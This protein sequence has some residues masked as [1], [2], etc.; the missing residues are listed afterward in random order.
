MV[1]CLQRHRYAI[2]LAAKPAGLALGA[3]LALS[4]AALAYPLW[5][6]F[7]GPAHYVGPAWPVN[8]GY[9]ADALDFV[10][11]TPNQA[12]APVLREMGT[13]LSAYSGTEDGAYLGLAVL[14]VLVCLVWW[15]RRSTVVRLGAGL[16]VIS[17][18][19]SLGRHLAVDGRGGNVPLPFDLLA[20]LPALDNILPIRFAFTTDACLAAVIAFGLDD[21]VR[22]SHERS[23]VSRQRPRSAPLPVAFAFTVVSVALVVTWLP[24]WPYPSQ[25]VNL[26]PVAVTKAIPAGNPIILAYPYPIAPEDQANLWQA[27][28]RRSFRL[29]GVYGFVAGVGRRSTTIPPLLNPPA[30]QEYLVGED[31]VRRFYPA[32]PQF[33]PVSPSLDQVVSQTRIFVARYGVQAVLVDLA[34]PHGRTVADMFTTAL[35]QPVVTSGQFDLWNLQK[36]PRSHQ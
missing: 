26:L 6:E 25:A 4:G 1:Y 7:D 31:G 15:C 34:A 21:L 33:Y 18:A 35:G 29:F 24:T 30:V 5:H 28:A 2:R 27:G 13:R 11:P 12:V 22:R 23:T 14:V 19:L 16:A 8:N 3:T 17:G 36:R 20:H 10:V 9:F 32:N